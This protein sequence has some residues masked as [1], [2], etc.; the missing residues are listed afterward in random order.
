MS[1][2]QL[3]EACREQVEL[4]CANA[5]AAARR[6]LDGGES[7]GSI[8]SLGVFVAAEDDFVAHSRVADSASD[9]L[10]HELGEAGIGARAASGVATLPGGA[11]VEIQRGGAV[12]LTRGTG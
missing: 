9:D 3:V 5:L 10:F 11:A 7:L 4:A 2:R 8:L 1:A 6:M 12:G